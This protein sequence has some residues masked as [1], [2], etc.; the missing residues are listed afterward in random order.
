[1]TTV[2]ETLIQTLTDIVGADQLITRGERLK[3]NSQDA[4]WYSPILKAQLAEKTADIIVQ[5]TT[6]DELAATIAVCVK[7]RVPITPRGAGTGNYGQSIPIYGGVLISTRNMTRIIERTPDYA[8][9]EAGTLLLTMER[10]AREIGAELRFFP[11]TLPTS[12][13]A[14][15]LAGGSW[16]RHHHG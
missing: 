8:R 11:S 6:V 1:M 2:S 5:P 14:G 10:S 16:Q 12:T 4:Y 7:A 15:F 3:R 13:A 9:V